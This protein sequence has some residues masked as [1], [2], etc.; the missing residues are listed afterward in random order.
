MTD[1]QPMMK[2]IS[3]PYGD[4]TLEVEVPD[5]IIFDG[6]M[7][8]IQPA[9]NFEKLLLER[10]QKPTGCGP[11]DQLV[12]RNDKVLILI[13]DNTRNTPLKK[14]LPVLV[15]YLERIG[16]GAQNVE[17]LTA[18]GTHRVMTEAEIIE[19]VGEDAA[20]SVKK[21]HHDFRDSE[22]L[23]DLGGV[24]AGDYEIPIQINKKVTEFDFI[25]GLGNIVPHCDAGFSG[26]AKI[27]QPGICGYSTTAATHAA[28]A[29]LTEIPLGVVEN[30]C[31]WGMEEVAKRVGLNFIINTVMNYKHEV[32]DIVAGDLVKAHRQGARISKKAFGV[33][34]PEPADIV[35]VSSHPADID[36]WQAEKGIISAYFAVKEGG[37]I[38]YAAPCPEG[39]EHNH[40]RFR[41]WLKL[42]YAE[43]CDLLKNTPLS[44]ETADMVSADLAICN[45]R[46]REKADILAVSHGLVET[47]MQILGYKPFKTVRDALDFALQKIPGGNIGI[48]PRGGDCLPVY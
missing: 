15:D 44:D 3:L 19:K 1:R 10:V 16:I 31:R 36:Y 35:I 9:A 34:I 7:E 42:S 48:L 38:I 37:F 17:L 13:E 27:L 23:I 41:E 6:T 30:P 4:E 24:Q 21:S 20:A 40:P 39:L 28:A 11:L 32:I 5:R 12:S 33:K 22:A 2:T 46:V 29:L 43:A 14:I 8:Y 47:D 26:G 25:I 45:A 18:P